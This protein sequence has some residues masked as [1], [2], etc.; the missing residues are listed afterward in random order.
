MEIRGEGGSKGRRCGRGQHAQHEHC[1]RKNPKIKGRSHQLME[2][3]HLVS[4]PSK[5]QR[6]RKLPM[7]Q[8]L[9]ILSVCSPLPQVFWF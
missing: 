7:P 1:Y 8:A 2:F 9:K 5:K 3:L 6:V 4:P